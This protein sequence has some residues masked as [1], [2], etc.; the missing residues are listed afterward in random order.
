[1][2]QIKIFIGNDHAALD[3]K[4]TL[5]EYSKKKGYDIEDLGT[6]TNQSCDYNDYALNVCKEVI[7]SNAIGILICG[8]GVG[9]S[10][11]ANKVKGIRC[12][13]VNDYDSTLKALEI[14]CNVISFGARTVGI[15]IA[16]QIVD[17]FLSNQNRAKNHEVEKEIQS[18]EE[19]TYGK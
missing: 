11:M 15:E 7:K 17:T 1:M 4:N 2:N 13:Q 16:K 3:Y 9:I 18:I 19:L 5:L 14:G 10:I 8:S 6:H 12:G